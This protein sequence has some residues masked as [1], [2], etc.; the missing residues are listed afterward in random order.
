MS[1]IRK[2]GNCG[3]FYPCDIKELDSLIDI[4]NKAL[5]VAPEAQENL[6]I[7]PRAIISPHAGYIYS[8]F[9]ANYA[10]RVLANA[11]SKRVVVIGPSHHVYFEGVSASRFE[12]YETPYRNLE[13]DLEYLNIMSK[14]FNLKFVKEAHYLEHST[15][16]QMPFIAKYQPNVKVIELIYGKVD[17]N[18]VAKII[19][20]LLED[21]LTSVVISTDL[22]HFHDL[23]KAQMLDS[24]CLEGIAKLDINILDIGCE[25]CGIIGVKGIIKAARELGLKSKILDYRTSADVTKDT[26]NVVGY[27]SAVFY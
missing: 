16:T 5:S 10:H 21:K 17:Y 11:K 20:W 25:A 12:F 19:K 24:I 9:S 1:S 26:S 23:Q 22:S 27:A 14:V 7:V 15:E 6:K 2:A 3:T 18:E 4:F 13:I 8:G